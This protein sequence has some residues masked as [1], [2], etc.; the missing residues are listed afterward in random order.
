[1]VT[2][3]TALTAVVARLTAAGLVEARSP[4]GVTKASQQ[5]IDRGFSVMPSS[6]GP[7]PH[8][9]RGKPTVSGLRMT[10]QFKVELAHKIKPGDGQA[11]PLQALQDY[12][13][14]IKYISANGTTLTTEGAII[15]SPAAHT[16]A[17]GGAYLLTAFQLQVTYELDLVI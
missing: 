6:I 14:A 11:A 10:Q 2:P 15:V 8:P 1:V 9:G 7:S 12:H 17:G 3:D 16:Y 5:R 4:L 13:T